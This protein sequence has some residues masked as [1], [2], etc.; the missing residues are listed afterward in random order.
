MHKSKTEDQIQFAALPFRIAADGRPRV[1]LLTSRETH[2]WVIPKGW[3]M[4]G[5]KPR[6]VAAR[7]AF[8]EAGLV[9]RIVG[10]KAVGSYHYS[11][12]LPP[13]DNILCE[14]FVFL[15][16]VEQQLDDWPERS[17]RETRWV[18]PQEAYELVREGGL[19][20]LMR[21]VINT[22]ALNPALLRTRFP[23]RKSDLIS[24]P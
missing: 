12:Q 2:R 16:E 13:H 15:F 9:G 10:K 4:R 24:A 21:R 11:K 14:V 17:Q 20:E 19:A 7:E 1:M 23:Q 3:P 6:E 18:G 8:E 5:R 22:V